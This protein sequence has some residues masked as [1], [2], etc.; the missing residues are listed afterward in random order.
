[1][2]YLAFVWCWNMKP[3]G[4]FRR[5]NSNSLSSIHFTEDSDRPNNGLIGV[6]VRNL[7]SSNG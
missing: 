3:S 2:A 6:P 5:I 7:V 4:T 1:M